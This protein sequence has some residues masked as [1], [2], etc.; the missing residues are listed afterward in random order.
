MHDILKRLGIE[1]VNPGGFAGQWVGSGP[2]LDVFTPVNGS[3]IASVQQVTE[4]EFDEIVERAH[5]AFLDWRKVPAPKRGEV[6]RQ[7]GNLLR[8]KKEDLGALVAWEMGKIVAEGPPSK[9]AR[10]RRSK[11]GKFLKKILP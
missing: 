8:A 6:V 7:L 3:R 2:V 11:T 4:Q 1:D 10:N 5:S 9:V